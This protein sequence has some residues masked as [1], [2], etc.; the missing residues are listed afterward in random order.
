MK[1]LT[2][3]LLLIF[4]LLASPARADIIGYSIRGFLSSFQ[5][6][7]LDPGGKVYISWNSPL[8]GAKFCKSF[9]LSRWAEIPKE[10]M[11]LNGY[12]Y[13]KLIPHF[14]SPPLTPDEEAANCYGGGVVLP[15]HVKD[16]GTLLDRPT[17]DAE[18]YLA[19]GT[20]KINGRVAITTI[21]DTEVI[22]KTPGYSYHYV[23]NKTGMRSLTACIQ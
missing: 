10:K 14:G 2:T 8:F 16:N 4:C 19:D 22:R 23:T 20:W 1:I 12:I 17:Y 9:D 11:D 6:N 13:D 5:I 7:T 3:N 21:C 18:L 15:W